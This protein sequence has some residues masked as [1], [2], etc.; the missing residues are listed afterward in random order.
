MTAWDVLLKSKITELP[1]DLEKVCSGLG[2][3]MFTT[4]EGYPLIQA[5]GL[6]D[7]VI[8]SEGFTYRDERLRLIFY[9]RPIMRERR[10]FTI[11]HEIGHLALGHDGENPEREEREANR[12]ASHL[13]APSCVL[14]GLGVYD[15]W[16]IMGLCGM[17]YSAARLCSERML[18]LE[19]KE[20]NYYAK[21]G[22]T[23]FF[24]SGTEWRLYEQFEPFIKS[25]QISS[26]LCGSASSNL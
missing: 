18:R 12:F 19:R 15:S 10:R 11:A 5:L 4:R 2:I 25:H 23:S 6:E 14:R 7:S 26:S 3:R 17:S 21:W 16:D 20:R 22:R 9:H 1:V 24:L 13:L 8:S